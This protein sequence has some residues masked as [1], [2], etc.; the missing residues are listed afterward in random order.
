MKITLL[1]APAKAGIHCG[2]TMGP[3]LRGDDNANFSFSPMGRRPMETPRRLDSSTSR[4][5]NH[6]NKARMSMK[7]K[8]VEEL[9]SRGVEEWKDQ[10][11]T[12]NVALGPQAGRRGRLL[13]FSTAQLLDSDF[14]RNK[15]RMSMK[16][17][18][19]DKKSRS[20]GVVEL[21]SGRTKSR[22]RMSP[23]GRRPEGADGSSTSRLLNFSTPIFNGT[24]RECL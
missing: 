13:D 4:L 18:D 2:P 14:Q 12:A 16:T 10:E 15:A 1:V 19:N 7:T 22:P 20:S 23:W 17:K 3:H 5:Q 9:R 8:E 24:K 11:P 21:G 6:G